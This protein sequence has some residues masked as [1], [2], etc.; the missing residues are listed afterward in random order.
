LAE[1]LN[2]PQ[3]TLQH[4]LRRKDSIDA[5]PKV[6]EFFESPEGAVF[7]HRL[8]LGAHFVMTLLGPCGVRRVCTFLEITGLDQFVAS[9]YGAQRKVTVAME[10]ATIE[11][12]DTEEK[13]LAMGMKPKQITVAEDETFHPQ[14]CLVAIEP[15]SNYILLE[16][17]AADRKAD[18]WT[19][20]MTAAIGEKPISVIQS[21]SDEGLGICSHAKNGLGAHHSPDLFHVQHE[22]VKATSGPLASKKRQAEK[23]LAE[24]TKTLQKEQKEQQRQQ[25]ECG[26]A[27][28]RLQAAQ[29]MEHAAK[30][31]LETR[32]NQQQRVQNANRALSA[33]YHPYDLETGLPRN[34]ESVSTPLEEQFTEIE[35][36]AREANL[37]DRSMDRI[38]K[39]KRVV[40]HMVATIAFFWLTVRAK[41][42]ALELTSSVETAVYDNLIPAIY[43]RLVADKTTDVV[44]RN[45]LR[46][47]SNQ[48]LAPLL[49][50]DGPLQTLA[51]AE[52][53]VLED[54]ARECASLF[55]RSSS[56]V[57]GRN[58][59]LSLRHHSLHR[60]SDRKLSALTI[61]HNFYLKRS[62]GTTAA[63]RFFDATPKDLFDWLLNQVDLPGYPALK[64]SKPHPSRYILAPSQY[65]P[66]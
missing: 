37:S 9:S 36:V 59:Q 10:Q 20:A 42:E 7:M 32:Q 3:S 47:K 63:E 30:S 16:Q 23:A 65:L 40:V 25:Q 29:E 26:D 53:Q 41:I 64:R 52:K 6:V 14:T 18:T 4:W 54:V 57:E 50:N 38:S 45:K 15:V 49:A 61:V 5:D 2:V 8:V 21:T 35:T 24:A 51:H 11:Y 56:C 48:L 62:N 27:S 28:K 66:L 12:G 22:I 44:Q 60:L 1:Q 33:A 31:A 43:L 19:E 55:Q 17:Y 58:G 34:A 13:R 46:Q 39:A